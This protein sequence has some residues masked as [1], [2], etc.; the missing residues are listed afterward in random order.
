M[1]GGVLGVG[2]IAVNKTDRILAPIEF[3]CQDR[4]GAGR[5]TDNRRR[6]WLGKYKQVK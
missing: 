6:Q 1:T 4:N 5:E 2:D 3:T